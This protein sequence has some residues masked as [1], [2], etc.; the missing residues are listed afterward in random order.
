MT[1]PVANGA[2]TLHGYFR[3]S[4]SWRVRIALGLKGLAYEQRTYRLREDDHRS[5]EFLSINPQG[6]V[7]ALEV[8]G[9]VLTQSLAICEYLDEAVP[10]PPLLPDGL[11]ERAL[12]RAFAQVIA[13]DIHPVQNLKILRRLSSLCVDD[14]AVQGWARDVIGDG[15][16]VCLRL[17]PRE[18]GRFCF[19][20]SPTLADICLIPQMANARRFGVEMIWPALESIEQHCM[21]LPA[22]ADAVPG[23]QPDCE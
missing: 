8:G 15:L 7:P 4:A 12:V 17:L 19:G 2:L 1:G 3:S 13:C 23:Q 9:M 20:D 14:A 22:F 11:V 16:E 21:A 6:L 10:E 18:R 5:A